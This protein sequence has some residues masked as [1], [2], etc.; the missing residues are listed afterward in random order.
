MP[1]LT[2]PKELQ[3]IL[4]AHG[5]QPSRRLGQNFLID[6]HVLEFIVDAARLQPGDHVLEVGP[7]AGVLTQELLAR[8]CHVLAVEKDTGLHALL[9]ERWASEPLLD[10]RLGD[11]LELDYAA[12]FAPDATRLLVSNLPYSV[13]TR[14]VVEAAIQETPPE[15]MV[16]LVQKE[17]AERFVAKPGTADMGTAS[18]WL[19]Q[20]YDVEIVRLV[21]P[22]CFWPAPDVTSAIVRMERH[23]R[24][25]LDAANRARLRALTRIAFQHRRKQMAPLYRNA[26]DGLAV[27]P[28]EMRA[29]L[30][31][32]GVPENARAEELTVEQWCALSRTVRYADL[33][34]PWR[35]EAP[36]R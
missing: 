20:V 35:M 33:G 13:G 28:D 11:A 16:V 22:S 26:P 36:A 32:L 12:V 19:Q 4:A 30:R 5:I 21:K 15:R 2:S 6:R 9:A 31:A 27:T 17:V 10:L 23:A 14:V 7:G 3:A 24:L 1:N 25:P 29:Q 8:G 18:V 34:I